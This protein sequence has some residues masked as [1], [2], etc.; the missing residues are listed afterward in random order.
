MNNFH[1]GED[2]TILLET[3]YA[4]VTTGTY[5]GQVHV[6]LYLHSFRKENHS[7]LLD[8]RTVYYD[9]NHQML[10]N[11]SILVGGSAILSHEPFRVGW[12]RTAQAIRITLEVREGGHVVRRLLSSQVLDSSAS[13]WHS[14]EVPVASIPGL[15][16]EATKMAIQMAT[17]A[18]A[19]YAEMYKEL[20]VKT[21]T[22]GDAKESY[23]SFL[24]TVK[25][26][27]AYN[28]K[29]QQHG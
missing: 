12:H 16:M 5:K 9:R 23:M 13:S 19:L 11:N 29:E 1:K 10:S 14:P 8:T 15:V 20:G 26:A 27:V 7:S 4:V 21:A 6:S 24:S 3:E 18:T 2:D 25:A 17:E 22:S 28:N